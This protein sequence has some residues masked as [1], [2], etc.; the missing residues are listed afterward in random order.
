MTEVNKTTKVAIV[1]G[2]NKG[3]GYAVVKGLCQKFNGVVYL[4]SRNVARGEAAIK[5]LKELGYH[6]SF[7]QLDVNDQESVNK[8]KDHILTTHGG[9]DIL[10]NNAGVMYSETPQDYENFLKQAEDTIETDYFALLRVSEAFLPLLRKDGRIVNV[11]SSAGHLSRLPSADLRTKFSSNTLTVSQLNELVNQ[12]LKAVKNKTN[13]EDGW[14]ERSYSIAKIAVCALTRIHQR[15]FDNEKRDLNIA[16]NSVHP[17]FVLTDLN[18]VG[19]WSI[20]SGAK[21]LL[22]LAL[23]NHGHKGLY[24]WKDCSVVDWLASTTPERH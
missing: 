10:V 12:Y 2:S 5:K 15:Y 9:I 13:K 1:T 4:T 7:H 21:P 16:V 17:G 14:G 3:I 19:E 22:Y 11:S 24:I 23:D 18:P 8:F 6:P 20:E